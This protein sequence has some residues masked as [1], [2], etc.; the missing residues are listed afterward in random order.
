MSSI[1]EMSALVRVEQT[2]VA[3]REVG[4]ARFSPRDEQVG[5][6]GKNG[7]RVQNL[8]FQDQFW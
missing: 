1:P 4:A 3:V 8:H 7:C 2:M 5:L 6:Q